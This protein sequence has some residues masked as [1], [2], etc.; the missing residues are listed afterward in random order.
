[1]KPKNRLTLDEFL[2]APGIT[3]DVRSPQ[4]FEHAHIPSSLNLPL[5]S[6]EERHEV[7]LCYTT[8]GQ[9]EAISLGLQYVAPK[10]EQIINTSK[11]YP[12]VKLLCWRGGM[13]S[14]S[15]AHLLETCGMDVYTLQG[16]YKTFRRWVLKMLETPKQIHILGGLTGSGKTEKLHQLKEQGEQILDLEALANHRGS[17][18][19][20]LGEQPSNEHFENLIALQLHQFSDEKPVWIEDESCYIGSCLV[21]HALFSQMK[22]APLHLVKCSEEERLKRLT[23]QYGGV[24]S[25]EL[26]MATERIRKK[27]GHER[28]EKAIESITS[29]DLRSA[30]KVILE[31][32]DKTYS[33]ALSRKSDKIVKY[34]D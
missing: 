18:F 32:Y 30:A 4:E 26:I 2:A 6:N 24:S 20:H 14:H 21:P 7:G 16:G 34:D 5:F 31:Y 17:S 1:M 13:R 27:L 29:G 9:K 25:Q 28:A 12:H 3:L 19:G 10:V 33:Y 23:T 11:Q 15:V 8:E 22:K